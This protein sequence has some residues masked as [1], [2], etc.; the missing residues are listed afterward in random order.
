MKHV[1]KLQLTN[2]KLAQGGEE[3]GGLDRRH[4]RHMER[5]WA[6]KEKIRG[7]QDN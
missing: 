6:Q 7:E 2:K 1:L 5:R 3:G 4:K